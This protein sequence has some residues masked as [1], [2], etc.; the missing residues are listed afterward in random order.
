[1]PSTFTGPRGAVIEE[2]FVSTLAV[3]L[4]SR[5]AQGA[6]TGPIPAS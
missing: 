6:L 4:R 1:V 5:L 3:E 2:P